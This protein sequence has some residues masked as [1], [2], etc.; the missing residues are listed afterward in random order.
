MAEDMSPGLPYYV[1]AC[2]RNTMPGS[3]RGI[4]RVMQMVKI[5]ILFGSLRE[6]LLLMANN[7][8]LPAVW[9]LNISEALAKSFGPFCSYL[10]FSHASDYT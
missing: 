2:A 6:L 3:L 4:I 8:I 9:L 5:I 7:V 10:G 1:S